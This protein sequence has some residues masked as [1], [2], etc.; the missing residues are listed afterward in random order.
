MSSSRSGII[1]AI[2]E[3]IQDR[4]PSLEEQTALAAAMSAY[5][6]HTEA[7]EPR[8]CAHC[9]KPTLDGYMIKNE[10]WKKAGYGPKDVLHLECLSIRLYHRS[11]YTLSIRDFTDAPINDVIRWGWHSRKAP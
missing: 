10:I 2:L 5:R 4:L 1:L 9:A 3:S 7:R 6:R 8:L 11:S